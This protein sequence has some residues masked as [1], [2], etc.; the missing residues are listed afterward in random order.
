[1]HRVA[2]SIQE[3]R[4][5]LFAAWTG[6]AAALLLLIAL[7]F[8]YLWIIPLDPNGSAVKTA[9]INRENLFGI[10]IG[11]VLIRNFAATL[12]IP[13][14]ALISR[15]MLRIENVSPV[16]ATTQVVAGAICILL[17][18]IPSANYVGMDFRPDRAIELYPLGHDTGWLM[19]DFVVGPAQVQMLAIALAVLAD[20]SLRP[21]LPRWYGY[22]CVWSA[23][24]ICA[25]NAIVVFQANPLTWDGVLAGYVAALVYISWL[26]ASFGAIWRHLR[27]RKQASFDREE[28]SGLPSAETGWH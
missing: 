22:F 21:I 14:F 23:I 18:I 5:E 26:L 3:R 9:Q 13:F 4:I 24:I 19:A 7:A 8:Y 28:W 20:S 1:M 16:L 10:E 17:F 2:S 12:M 15:L 11:N 6:P 25:N 27:V